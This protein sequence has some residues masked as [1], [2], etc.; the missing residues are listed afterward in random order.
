MTA[1]ITA[2]D[3]ALLAAVR[4]ALADMWADPVFVRHIA[5]SRRTARAIERQLSS[6]S[7]LPHAE[8]TTA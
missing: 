3:A 6:G 4:K 1:P 7:I 5:M 2:E 8:R